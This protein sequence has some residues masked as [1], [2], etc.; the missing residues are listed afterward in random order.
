VA[1][2]LV[3]CLTIAAVRILPGIGGASAPGGPGSQN[4]SS[5]VARVFHE[6][7]QNNNLNWQTG[8]SDQGF[9]ATLPDG[10]QYSVNVPQGRTGF[11]YPQSVGTLPESFTLIASIQETAGGPTAFYGMMLHFAQQSNGTSGYGFF[12]NNTGQCQIIKYQSATSTPAASAQGSYT[13]PGQAVHTLKVQAQGSHY[14]FFVDNQAMVFATSSNPTNTT[15]SDG[16]LHAGL[17]A[18]ALSGPAQGST[19]PQAIFVITGLQLNIP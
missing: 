7:F 11:P 3:A 16:N 18:L 17:L 12:I 13:T 19:E 8:S 9:S 10:G 4:A 5:G 1:L 2:V 15:W 14:F 6:Q